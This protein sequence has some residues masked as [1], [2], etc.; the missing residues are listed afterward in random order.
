[1]RFYGHGLEHQGI[2]HV[3]DE[4]INRDASMHTGHTPLYR[5]QRHG[6]ADF[7]YMRPIIDHNHNMV[8]RGHKEYLLHGRLSLA[9]PQGSRASSPDRNRP[10]HSKL[11]RTHRTH[12]GTGTSESSS[13]IC[14]LM[15]Q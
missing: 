8:S 11:A 3:H 13:S 10:S 12:S 14:Q 9:D 6:H 5:S 2:Y 7:S 1:M 15:G 4:D